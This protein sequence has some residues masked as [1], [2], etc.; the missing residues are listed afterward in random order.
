VIRKRVLVSGQVQGVYFRDTCRRKALA[1]GVRGWV[2]N[3]PDRRV[4]AVF[5]GGPEEVDRMLD[6]ARRGPA[7][8]VVHRVEIYDESPEG[9]W[10]FEIT[11]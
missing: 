9:L 5:E 4:E 7:H 3:L 10:S 6:W 1:L 8:A 11:A 2:R